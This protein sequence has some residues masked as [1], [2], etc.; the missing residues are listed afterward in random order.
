MRRHLFIFVTIAC[1]VTIACGRRHEPALAP[2]L[3]LAE[4][5]ATY[6][7][8]IAAGN[9]PTPYQNGTGERIGLFED[10]S[11]VVWGLP[12]TATSDGAVHVCASPSVSE[13]AVTDSIP[14]GEMVIGSTNEPTGWRGGTGRLELLLR[15]G[16]GTIR[17]WAVR[18]AQ[19][20][21]G[22]ACRGAESRSPSPQAHYFKL[23][24]A[25]DLEQ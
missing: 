18:G 11:G 8:L 6:G 25:A 1:N 20:V 4:A 24:P 21:S 14:A 5:E 12:L 22:P 15:D 3:S 7:P 13:A 17:W 2:Y 19:L 9:C 16:R 23:A 10:A